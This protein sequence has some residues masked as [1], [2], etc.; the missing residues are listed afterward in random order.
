MASPIGEPFSDSLAAIIRQR[1][2]KMTIENPITST[3]SV[4]GVTNVLTPF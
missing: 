1:K 2:V 3:F 4:L